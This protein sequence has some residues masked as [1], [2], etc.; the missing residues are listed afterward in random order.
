M[1]LV[2]PLV[3]FRRVLDVDIDVNH[4]NPA[5]FLCHVSTSSVE[6]SRRPALGPRAW[7]A[8]GT[9]GTNRGA[10]P[11]DIPRFRGCRARS[12]VSS[13]HT[14]MKFRSNEPG[15]QPA[16]AVARL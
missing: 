14:A 6:R 9:R 5:T 4:E 11:A 13:G 16:L 8:G 12:S 2:V 7:S 15:S 10:V 3:E 1:F